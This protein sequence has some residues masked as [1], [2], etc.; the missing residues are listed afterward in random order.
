MKSIIFYSISLFFVALMCCHDE[1]NGK[2]IS[3]NVLEPREIEYIPNLAIFD[4][5]GSETNFERG[6]FEYLKKTI[7]YFNKICNSF[8]MDNNKKLDTNTSKRIIRNA[9]TADSPLAQANIIKVQKNLSMT[10]E[11]VLPRNVTENQTQPQIYY[12]LVTNSTPSADF[13]SAALIST[14]PMINNNTKQNIYTYVN[15]ISFT[16]YRLST[17]SGFTTIKKHMNFISIAVSSVISLILLLFIRIYYVNFVKH[18]NLR[19]EINQQ[20]EIMLL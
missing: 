13:L 8:W 18:R 20:E 3:L 5:Y 15:K 7:D 16:L 19:R 9:N 12:S 10:T 17:W 14:G 11:S 1:V 2:Y 4:D 6:Y